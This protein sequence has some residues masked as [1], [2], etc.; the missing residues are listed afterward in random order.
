MSSDYIPRLRNELLRAGATKPSR[1]APAA[2]ALRPLAAAAAVAL[3]VLAVALAVPRGDEEVARP[4]KPPA[5]TLQLN[6]RGEAARGAASER[7]MR[8][9]L[10]AAG[11]RDAHVSVSQG[12]TLALTVPTAARADVAALVHSGRFAVYDWERSLVGGDEP[13][14]A[15]QAETRGGHPVL[16][17]DGSGWLALRG[18]PALTSA[19]VASASA[20]TDPMTDQP[21]VAL[22]LTPAGQDAFRALTR[23]LAQRGG[24]RLDDFQ[25]LGIVVDDRVYSVPY[26][27][28]RM[29]PDGLD[30]AEGMHISG[31]FTRAQARELA[32]VLDSG[33]LPGTI[34]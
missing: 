17:E 25:H 19:A 13:V 31:D 24:D 14:G 11:V 22:Q 1:W 20:S 15:H 21:V 29:A 7:V 2:H 6:Y 8:E 10:A 33:P 12:G 34:R 4:S 23:T 5:G 30:G 18:E 32:A 9:R 28:G 27:D 26:I 3:V 16:A